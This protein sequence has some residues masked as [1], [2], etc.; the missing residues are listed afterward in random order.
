MKAY[1][2]KKIINKNL[3]IFPPKMLITVKKPS[4][5]DLQSPGNIQ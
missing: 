5:T 1:S 4:F 3:T 2:I